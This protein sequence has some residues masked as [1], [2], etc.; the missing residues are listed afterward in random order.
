MQLV[1]APIPLHVYAH[2]EGSGN[3]ARQACLLLQP[4]GGQISQSR[5]DY[6]D[7]KQHAPSDEHSSDIRTGFGAVPLYTPL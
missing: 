6:S 1:L 3:E 5:L 7:A 4:S 2:N